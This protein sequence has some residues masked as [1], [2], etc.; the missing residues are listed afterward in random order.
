MTMFVPAMFK[1]K[2]FLTSICFMSNQ[3]N[4]ESCSDNRHHMHVATSA[5]NTDTLLS[6]LRNSSIKNSGLSVILFRHIGMESV[7]VFSYTTINHT[8]A[9]KSKQNTNV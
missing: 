9:I 6:P 8:L 7:S 3:T 1:N 4:T 2:Q 5:N